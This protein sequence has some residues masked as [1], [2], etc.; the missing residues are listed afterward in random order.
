MAAAFMEPNEFIV[1]GGQIGDGVFL[2]STEV[3]S[4]G[5]FRV[6][7]TLPGDAV[8]FHCLLRISD[9]ELFLVGGRSSGDNFTAGVPA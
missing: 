9:T 1:S 7:P 6:G 3:L 5:I 4:E 8:H 2:K